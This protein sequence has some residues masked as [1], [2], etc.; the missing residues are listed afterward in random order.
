M[1]ALPTR[2]S[3]RH[4]KNEAKD[5]HKIACWMRGVSPRTRL[6]RGFDGDFGQADT[7]SH[8]AGG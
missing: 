1:P 7:A 6:D 5:L 4:L 3:L 2:P 8:V